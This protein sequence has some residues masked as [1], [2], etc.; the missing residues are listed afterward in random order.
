ML[1][2]AYVFET[3]C[4]QRHVIE[5]PGVSTYNVSRENVRPAGPALYMTPDST[6]FP[7]SPNR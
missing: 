2:K 5:Y 3:Q 6:L 7:F 4:V 1:G